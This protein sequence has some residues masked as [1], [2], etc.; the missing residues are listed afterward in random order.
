MR[1]SRW[2]KIRTVLLGVMVALLFVVRCI[3]RGTLRTILNVLML[4][5]A[6]GTMFVYII[7]WRCPFCG[8][9]MPVSHHRE[10]KFCPLCGK[11]IQ[12]EKEK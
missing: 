5:I 10:L 8:K 3:P 9:Y 1:L 6:V 12:D 11:P 7:Y 4:A 2:R